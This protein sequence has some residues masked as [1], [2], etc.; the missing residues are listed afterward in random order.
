MKFLNGITETRKSELLAALK[1]EW[2]HDST[3][4]EG[5]TLTLGDTMFVLSYG[6]TVK[7]KPL[8]DQIDVQNH[9]R[10]IDRVFEI[11]E[12][13][14]LS[15]EDLFDLHLLVI[16]EQ[17]RDIYK[18]VGAY[19]REDNGTYRNVDGKSVYHAYLPADEVSAAMK[20]WLQQFNGFYK[21]DATE[22]EI[23]E[24]YVRSHLSFTSIHPFY[25]GNGRLARLIS[26]L[27]VLFAGFPPIVIPMESRE[28]YLRALQ[29]GESGDLE[30]FRQLIRDS[31]CETR[32]LVEDA[33][34]DSSRKCA[35]H[36]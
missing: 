10:A 32:R 6:L 35:R 13:G 24:A 18:P 8:R 4:L 19:K 1:A 26:N 23:I 31:W 27:P 9:A 21:V 33:R 2:T 30:P 5:N 17:S 16:N 28:E 20:K 3:A 36:T 25:D 12:R 7:G 22:N 15:E 14:N 11:F 29:I 34:N